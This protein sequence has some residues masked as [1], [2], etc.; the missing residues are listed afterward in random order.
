[1]I[2]PKL[3]T[4][5]EIKYLVRRLTDEFLGGVGPAEP[6]VP[7]GAHYQ[8]TTVEGLIASK[9]LREMAVGDSREV[10]NK[11]RLRPFISAASKLKMKIA[12]RRLDKGEYR[13]WKISE[14]P[15][16]QAGLKKA[17][18][19]QRKKRVSTKELAKASGSPIVP[20]TYP[21]AK[22]G[23]FKDSPKMDVDNPK[24]GVDE[25]TKAAEEF[26][27]S[28]LQKISKIRDA[29]TEK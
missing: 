28:R 4:E 21:K 9:A 22:K 8:P 2:M 11:L 27:K 13:M 25:L 23:G 14:P 24:M 3:F 10:M 7:I 5:D 17:R 20:E 15:V 18:E 19:A 16:W 29:P 26:Q 12:F 6:D 1:M